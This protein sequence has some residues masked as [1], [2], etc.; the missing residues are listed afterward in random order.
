MMFGRKRTTAR[1]CALLPSDYMLVPQ[2]ADL[3]EGDLVTY[4]DGVSFITAVVIAVTEDC[5][6]VLQKG[7]YGVR[8]GADAF[9]LFMPRDGWKFVAGYRKASHAL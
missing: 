8:R 1:K 9:D 6:P 2:A 7:E 3:I 5:R 4:Y